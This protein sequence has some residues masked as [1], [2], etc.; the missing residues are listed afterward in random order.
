MNKASPI[1]ETRTLC[2][3][4]AAKYYETGDYNIRRANPYQT[5]G[6]PCMLCRSIHG[7]DYIISKKDKK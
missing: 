6:E 7:K 3:G 4:C 2:S 5:I 1:E